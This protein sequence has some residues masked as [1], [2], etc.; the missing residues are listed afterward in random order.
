[1]AV[2]PMPQHKVEIYIQKETTNSSFLEM[3][4]FL[5]AKGIKNNAFMLALYDTDL[6]GVDPYDPNLSSMMKVK[7]LR[8]VMINNWYFIR[9]VVRI[10]EIGG[11]GI[12]TRY[13]LNRGNLAINYMMSLNFNIFAELPRQQGKSVCIRVYSLWL[14]NFATT[15]SEI[16]FIHKNHDGSK[17]NLSWVKRYRENLPSYLR[18]DAPVS[19]YTG[20]KL[21]VPNTAEVLQH[22][23]NHNRI[24]TLPS[25]KNKQLANTLGR[26]KRKANLS[27]FSNECVPTVLIAKKGTKVLELQR[28][29]KRSA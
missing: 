18:M 5:K 27:V 17:E 21:K 22:P 15:N 11:S 19:D 1:M 8:E 25:A 4:Y 9:E 23:S 3:H 6:I 7:I 28:N 2:L 12:G 24:K 10:P 14:L 16:M 13:K 29:R 20:K 26:E